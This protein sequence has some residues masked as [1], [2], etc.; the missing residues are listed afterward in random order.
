MIG[1][2]EK[3]KLIEKL[4]FENNPSILSVEQQIHLNDC[5]DCRETYKQ[6]LNIEAVLK[7][8]VIYELGQ[9]AFIKKPEKIAKRQ[10][11]PQILPDFFPKLWASLTFAS[12]AILFFIFSSLFRSDFS[13]DFKAKLSTGKIS[14]FSGETYKAGE[15]IIMDINRKL[16]STS[17]IISFN[18]YEAF[19]ENSIFS[20]DHA[21]FRIDS[22]SIRFSVV[23]GHRLEVFTKDLRITVLGTEFRVETVGGKSLLEVYSGEVEVTILANKRTKICRKGIYDFRKDL[24][25][26]SNSGSATPVSPATF[27]PVIETDFPKIKPK[28]E[29]LAS[30]VPNSTSLS[31]DSDSAIIEENPNDWSQIKLEDVV[32]Q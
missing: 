16:T 13:G 23:P 1:K 8:H 14:S 30:D 28:T 18:K 17:A 32:P 7:E 22:G 6:I 19:I 21:C 25:S 24:E 2:K 4:L 20:A 11:L 26:Q 10:T 29:K 9:V 12:L 3:C 5:P 27:S 31:Q 15:K